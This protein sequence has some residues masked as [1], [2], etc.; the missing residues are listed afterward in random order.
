MTPTERLLT[1]LRLVQ[2]GRERG[3]QMASS[4]RIRERMGDVY[5]ETAGARMWRRDIATL[6]DRGLIES[7]LLTPM[8]PNRTGMRLCIPPKPERLH[9]T[10][11]ELQAI[12]R[13]RQALQPGISAVSPLGAPGAA[14]HDIDYTTRIVRFLEENEDEVEL[15]QLSLWLELPESRVYELVDILTKESVVR[16]GLVCS[17]EFGYA[18]GEETDDLP[19]TVRVFRGLLGRQ[20]PTRGRGMD[21]PGLTQME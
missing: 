7:D 5:E 8:I 3:V 4:T 2:E 6:R 17:V 12:N 14:Q 16:G 1:I 18:D 21:H 11:E 20:S 9:L 10:D 13:A 15:A 19:A